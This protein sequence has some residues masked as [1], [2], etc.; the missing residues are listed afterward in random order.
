MEATEI[1]PI[2]I[3]FLTWAIATI[4]LFG[5][6]A[7]WRASRL[8][9]SRTLW[10]LFGG[11]LGPVAWLMLWLAPPAWCPVCLAPSRGW[12]LTCWWCRS[13]LRGRTI[14]PSARRWGSAGAH[15]DA[16]AGW[17]AAVGTALEDADPTRPMG[18]EP[19]V[20][21]PSSTDM[22]PGRPP[23]SGGSTL[24]Y[25][26][27]PVMGSEIEPTRGVSPAVGAIRAEPGSLSGVDPAGLPTKAPLTAVQQSGTTSGSPPRRILLA[28]AVYFAGTPRLEIGARYGLVVEGTRF[29]LMGPYDPAAVAFDRPLAGLAATVNE[30]RLLL[31]LPDGHDAIA[32]VF[33]SISGS[34][35][36]LVA[37]ALTKAADEAAG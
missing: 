27:I 6:V 32:L 36:E 31:A 1:P 13:P 15:G 11:L 10:F 25:P 30:G 21:A 33:A 18:A 7:A 16:A 17:S 37:K 23:S 3:A 2:A 19:N 24:A 34:T 28:V 20:T 14:T 9:R 12:L 29:K 5:L 4:V 26:G 22:G 8:G 35:P